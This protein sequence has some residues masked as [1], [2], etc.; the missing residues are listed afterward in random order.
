MKKN[1]IMR[2]KVKLLKPE[3]PNTL[4]EADMTYI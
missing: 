2:S 4:W 3:A 1:E